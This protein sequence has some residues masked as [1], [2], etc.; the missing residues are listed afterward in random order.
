M[1]HSM[2]EFT[3]QGKQVVGNVRRGNI[4][5]DSY[6]RLSFPALLK[7]SLGETIRFPEKA[8]YFRGFFRAGF[9]VGPDSAPSAYREG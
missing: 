1:P 8:Y 5:I 7:F 2:A 6:R 4:W 3:G 9:T